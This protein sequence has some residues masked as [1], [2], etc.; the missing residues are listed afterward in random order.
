MG[1]AAEKP[2]RAAHLVRREMKRLR[3][4]VQFAPK[5]Q[6]DWMGQVA[7]GARAIHL[8]LAELRDG[9]VVAATLEKVRARHPR[10]WEEVLPERSAVEALGSG[11]IA[12]A[13]AV[14]RGRL[15]ELRTLIAS[16][17]RKFGSDAELGEA[18]ARSYRKARRARAIVPAAIDQEAV[19]AWR[20]AMY[21]LCFQ[22]QLAEPLLTREARE[23]EGALLPLTRKLGRCG[24]LAMARQRLET[25]EMAGVKAR[26]RAKLLEWIESRRQRVARALIADTE[27]YFE[28]RPREFAQ[29]CLRRRP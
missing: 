16:A 25:R 4:L 13:C 2:N 17:G 12:T 9:C 28:R 1:S 21:R 27:E 7:S 26:T 11:K 20:K 8:E 14:A 19:H 22:L 24:D 10:R 3:A 15:E 29:W 5:P 6:P 23:L 18:L